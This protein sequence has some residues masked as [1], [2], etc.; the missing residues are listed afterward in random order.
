MALRPDDNEQVREYYGKVLLGKKDLQTNACCTADQVSARF[1]ALLKNIDEEILDRFYGCGA[2]LPEALEGCTVLDLGCGTGRDVYLAAQLTG[3]EGNVIGIDMTPEQLEVAERHLKP[4]MRKFGYL[5]PN[6]SFRHGYIEDL[7]AAGITDNSVD[8]VISNCVINLSPDK[9]RVFSE[10]FRVLKP[11]GE[12]YI[13]DVFVDR[14]LPGALREDPVLLGECLSGAMYGEDFR[15]LVARLGCADP[16]EMSRAAITINNPEI[17]AKIGMANFHSVTVRA[18]K[19]DDLE[20]RCEDYGQVAYYQGTL[21][22]APHAFVLDGHHRFETRRPYPVCGN[23]ASMLEGTRF[24]PHFRIEGDRSTHF[25]H[26][27]CGGAVDTDNG[28]IDCC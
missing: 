23:T 7:A 14:R 10:I 8:V 12:M 17:E 15:R 6:V 28:A 13:A 25:G 24:A 19:L 21:P 16:R 18:F 9:E 1:R 26:F 11:G 27:H 5:S 20:D 4:Q 3:P 2:P 22:G